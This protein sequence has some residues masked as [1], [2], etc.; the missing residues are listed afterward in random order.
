MQFMRN[1]RILRVNS[2][3]YYSSGRRY[4]RSENKPGGFPVTPVATAKKS[5][6]VYILKNTNGET[7][8]RVETNSLLHL[9][10]GGV[11]TPQAEG[12]ESALVMLSLTP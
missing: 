4:R 8:L 1:N 5:Y 9:L 6:L 10:K 2:L 11:L 12:R 7:K 3:K